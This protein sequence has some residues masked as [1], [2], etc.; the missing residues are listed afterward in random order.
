MN[1]TRAPVLVLA[2][3]IGSSCYPLPSLAQASKNLDP[4]VLHPTFAEEIA[5]S[6]GERKEQLVVIEGVR[7][8][9]VEHI[10]QSVLDKEVERLKQRE[11]ELNSDWLPH[12]TSEVRDIWGDRGYFTAQVTVEPTVL[13]MDEAGQH[14]SLLVRVA[15]GPQYRLKE[16]RIERATVFSADEL[17]ALVPLQPGDIFDVSKIREGLEAMRRAYASIGYIDFTV[18]PLTSIDKDERAI[19][20]TLEAD[21]QIQF[22]WGEIEVFGLDP[23]M[24]SVLRSEFLPGQVADFSRVYDF[25]QKHKASFPLDILTRRHF[26]KGTVDLSFDFRRPCANPPQ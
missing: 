24:E 12:V 6:I 25:L 7:F 3:L 8:E 21:E 15:E 1:A 18:Q 16:I 2:V 14:V 20:L 17:R 9:G 13:G 5:A 11:L 26:K 10:S 22:R 23:Q 4:C 19:T